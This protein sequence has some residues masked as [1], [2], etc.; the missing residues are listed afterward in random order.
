MILLLGG[1][2]DAIPLAELLAQSGYRV[3]VSKATDTPLELGDHPR[4]E[5]RAGPLDDEGLGQL[6]RQRGMRAVVDA[7]HPYA[8]AIHRRV[9]RVAAALGIPCL[10][11]VRPPAIEADWP[12]VEWVAS[13]AAA[14]AAA[15]THGRPVLVTTGSR[16]LAPYA[17]ESRR[18]GL[19]L[20]VR[21]LDSPES[22][23]ACRLAGIPADRI[24][25]GRGPFSVEENRRQIRAYAIG[26]LVTKDSGLA[27]G[28]PEKLEAARVENCRIVVVRRPEGGQAQQFAQREALLA[29]LLR[30][31]PPGDALI[32]AP[33]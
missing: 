18:S 31:A 12:G 33:P 14:A 6:I 19:P 16:H 1:T 21:V 30:L 17:D 28:T 10:G 3:L 11:F 15:F 20:V 25:T 29:A 2:S 5:S 4:I 24:L 13:H 27:G 26:A 8:V 23:A 32:S 7:A 9:A 22:L